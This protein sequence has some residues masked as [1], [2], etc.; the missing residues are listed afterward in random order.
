MHK[1]R[2][3]YMYIYHSYHSLAQ[4]GVILARLHRHHVLRLV[5]TDVNED[6][7]ERVDSRTARTGGAHLQKRITTVNRIPL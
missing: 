1:V 5:L 7:V 4:P 3:I 2:C 6:V